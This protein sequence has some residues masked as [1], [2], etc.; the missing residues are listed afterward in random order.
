MTRFRTALLLGTAVALVFT[1]HPRL[2]AQA[3]TELAPAA[4]ISPA[5]PQGLVSAAKAE[6]L[7]WFA[8]DEGKRNVYTAAAPNFRP[9]RVT[10]F[11]EDDGID[12]TDVQISDDGSMVAFVRGHAPNR[13]G[14]VANP[15]SNPDGAERAI[16]AARTSGGRAWRVTEGSNYELSP[17]GR[18]VLFAQDGQIHRASTAENRP[19]SARD[20]GEEPFITAWGTNSNPSWSPDG[21][22]IAFVS[23]RTD[24]SFVVIAGNTTRKLTYMAPSVD[25]DASPTWSADGKQIAFIR[26]PGTPFGRQAQQ[27]GGGI[28]LPGGPAFQPGTQGRRGGGGGGRGGG[29]GGQELTGPG[30]NIPGLMRATFRGGYTTSIWVGDV[31]TAE[32][33]EVWHTAPD[34]QIFTSISNIRWADGHVIF[35][36]N[37]AALQSEWERYFS[38]NL[39]GPEG[40]APVMLTTTDGIIEDAASVTLS[41]DGKTLFY[42]TNHGDIDRRHIWAV[43]VAGGAPKQVSL[44]N[45]IEMYPVV[46]AS[47]TRLAAVTADWNRPQSVSVIDVDDGEQRVIF[48][49]PLPRAFPVDAHVKPEAVTLKAEDGF[50][51]YNQMWVPKD[52]RPGERRPAMIFV[53]GGP[54]RQMLL[55][56]HYR[57]FYHMAYGV[58]EWLASRGYVV[59]S[60]NYRSG[61]GYGTSFRRA[62]DTGGRGNAEYRDV[63]AAGKYLQSRPDVDPDRIGIWGLSYGGV[64]TGQALARNSDIFKVGIDLAG[65]HLWGNSVNPEDESFQSSVIGAIDG[66]KSPVLLIHGDD[67]RNV[68]FQQTTGLVQLLRAR[69]VEFELIVFPDDVHDSLVHSRWVYTF[70]RMDQFLK[71]HMPVR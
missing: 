66:W 19:A 13:Q 27:G 28:G 43:P 53:H 65:V 31:A 56:Y 60:V 54:S 3:Q 5:Y 22:K 35:T 11:L 41:K 32:A 8:Y 57:H 36:I 37:V 64:L 46:L 71:K 42:A 7:A 29:R 38:I 4:F 25:F 9:V 39:S 67:D 2:G 16:W 55:G 63:L 33:K 18:W 49:N 61:V 48:P 12:L 68:A 47:G 14:W 1:A 10:S 20:R 34:E 69:D 40:A 58:N 26:R 70:D 52:L 62:P 45:A 50:E 44:G 17:D 6:R 23:N 51:F 21:S 30:S 15:L 24:H 59:M